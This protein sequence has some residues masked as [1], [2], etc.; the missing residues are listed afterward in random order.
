[1]PSSSIEEEIERVVPVVRAL[2]G[3]TRDP[4]VF[5]NKALSF[6]P[7]DAVWLSLELRAA[8]RAT[9]SHGTD[10][11]LMLTKPPWLHAII[12]LWLACRWAAGKPSLL[13]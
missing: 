5:G 6:V 7:E 3:P 11:L 8:V 9:I 10:L 13:G 4:Q 1:M 2:G 12:G